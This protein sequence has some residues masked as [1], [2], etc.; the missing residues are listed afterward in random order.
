MNQNGKRNTS[1]NG[2]RHKKGSIRSLQSGSNHSH[3]NADLSNS[4]HMKGSKHIRPSQ[5]DSDN[6]SIISSESFNYEKYPAPK[7]TSSLP[8]SQPPP[9]AI[10]SNQSLKLIYLS[11]DVI[12]DME[13]GKKKI[14]E[15]LFEL[16][17]VYFTL[18]GIMAHDS[19]PSL[20]LSFVPIV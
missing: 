2:S 18:I 14:G 5:Y 12:K 13:D 1:L 4:R 19:K 7:S 3:R 20:T 6:D 16:Y 8:V 15:K 10:F 11:W 9:T 17:V